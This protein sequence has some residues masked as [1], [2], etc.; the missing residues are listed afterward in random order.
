M[1]DLSGIGSALAINLT[2]PQPSSD[3]DRTFDLSCARVSRRAIAMT[4]LRGSL[5]RPRLSVEWRPTALRG[6]RP[7]AVKSQRRRSAALAPL[8]R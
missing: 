7:A 5:R 1:A 4:S 6:H 8:D 2:V 3:T